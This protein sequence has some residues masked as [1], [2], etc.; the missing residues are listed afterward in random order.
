VCQALTI[1]HFAL[2]S[3]A[4]LGDCRRYVHKSVSEKLAIIKL[5]CGLRSLHAHRAEIVG[6]LILLQDRSLK[7]TFAG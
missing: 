5:P 1:T 2:L 6:M 7:R 4:V 3:E